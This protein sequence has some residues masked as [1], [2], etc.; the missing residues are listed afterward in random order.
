MHIYCL[1][2]KLLHLPIDFIDK[3]VAQ[4][5]IKYL[6]NKTTS[7]ILHTWAGCPALN[8]G[9]IIMKLIW[10]GVDGY[11][12]YDDARIQG[13]L[14]DDGRLYTQREGFDALEVGEEVK[15]EDL[16]LDEAGERDL[17]GVV[18]TADF[19]VFLKA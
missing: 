14:A 19:R 8:Q 3:I 17:S 7:N 16:P 15:I 10:N 1:Y 4:T 18:V 2:R 5:C 6:T 9:I 13:L 12:T 11:L